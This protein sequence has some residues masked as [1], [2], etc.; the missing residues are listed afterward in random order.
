[1]MKKIFLLL[2]IYFLLT[3]PGYSQW[4]TYGGNTLWPYG[5]VLVTKGALQVDSVVTYS[6]NLFLKGSQ[7]SY[8]GIQNL[9][10]YSQLYLLSE[11]YSSEYSGDISLRMNPE[12]GL[13]ALSPG[14][15]SFNSS[16][17]AVEILSG[18]SSIN[19]NQSS[20]ISFTGAGKFRFNSLPS[21]SSGLS[22]G[23][24]YFDPATGVVK[25]KY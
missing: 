6:G 2:T 1:M 15:I 13:V 19:I 18:S 20:G 10:A 24:L 21:D 12:E 3:T 16:S 25:R 22:T 5:N 23:H 9:G 4:W 7:N 8:M 14:G 11:D 17:A